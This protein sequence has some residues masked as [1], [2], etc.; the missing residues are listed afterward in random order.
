MILIV[1]MGVPKVVHMDVPVAHLA[2]IVAKVKQLIGVALD[3]EQLEVV[4]QLVNMVVIRTA[5]G[6]DVGPYAE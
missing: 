3:V 4:H 6:G 5:S 2:L 1:V